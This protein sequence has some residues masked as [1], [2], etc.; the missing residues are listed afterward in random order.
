M[1]SLTKAL[2]SDCTAWANRPK[3][4][5]HG[6]TRYDSSPNSPKAHNNLAFALTVP[7]NRPRGDYDEALVHCARAVQLEPH[8]SFF[9][10]LALAEYRAGHWALSLAAGERSLA[11]TTGGDA[12]VWFVMALA[13]WRKGD[14]G[15]ARALFDKAADWAMKHPRTNDD[16]QRQLWS[17]AA[18]L[19]GLPGPGVHE[20]ASQPTSATRKAS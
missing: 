13:S 4:W 3:P 18:N 7:P 10:T 15:Q 8:S 1:R 11:M 14:Q 17:E 19:L 12:N 2:P 16:D 6:A 5:P 9:G 20:P